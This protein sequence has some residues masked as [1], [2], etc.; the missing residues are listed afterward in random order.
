MAMTYVFYPIDITF[1]LDN[2]AC[3]V[4]LFGRTSDKKSITVIDTGYLPSF[5]IQTN[6]EQLIEEISRIRLK[7]DDKG[8]FVIAVK[9]IK[10]IINNLD[11]VFYQVFVNRPKAISVI[12][13]AATRKGLLVLENDVPFLNKYLLDN[14]VSFFRPYLVEGI[15]IQKKIRTDIIVE[16]SV[17]EPAIAPPFHPKILAV[18][19]LRLFRHERKNN[20]IAMIN[21]FSKK[22]SGTLTYLDLEAN[23][24]ERS[25]SE[26]NLIEMFRDMVIQEQPDIIAGYGSDE[27]LYTLKKRAVIY[28]VDLKLGADFSEIKYTKVKK[29]ARITG[30]LHI[31]LKK[32]ISPWTTTQLESDDFDLD[33]IRQELGMRNN[34]VDLQ[35]YVH[36]APKMKIRI[37]A[38][39]EES[40]LVYK[41]TKKLF[42]VLKFLID[43]TNSDPFNLTRNSYFEIIEAM[44]LKQISESNNIIPGLPDKSMIEERATFKKSLPGFSCAPGYYKELCG[45]D[46]S[47][48]KKKLITEYNIS[49]DTVECHCCKIEHSDKEIWSCS[50]K[51]GNIPLLIK[52]FDISPEFSGIKRYFISKIS[53]Y[54]NFTYSR[55]YSKKAYEK[56]IDRLEKKII[57]INRVLEE[58]SFRIMYADMSRILFS[59]GSRQECI[60]IC[61]IL[62]SDIIHSYY[63]SA[64]FF[65]QKKSDLSNHC[66]LLTE[67]GKMV[68][69]G[70]DH[71]RRNYA[72]IVRKTWKNVLKMILQGE[73]KHF[74]LIQIKDI[75]KK[76]RNHEI[77][78]NDVIIETQL[79]KEL[80]DY[81][82]TPPHVA[83]ARQ[84][85]KQGNIISKGTAIRYIIGKG[86][87]KISQRTMLP[88]D[89]EKDDYDPEYY[90]H[91]QLIR[92]L[93]PIIR[94]L[95]YTEDDV[96]Q[97]RVQSKLDGF[98]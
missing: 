90:I 20:P 8:Y 58:N 7:I 93:L 75:I 78:L 89:A 60:D 73:P 55:I 51:T 48:I 88:D 15:P 44:L 72:P 79:M 16:K 97:D 91:N 80:D 12:S 22:K 9:K 94:A 92:A 28:D 53:N 49:P 52:S 69:C 27:F 40:R 25:S 19:S 77:G 57:D 84:S 59:V 68:E 38:L 70:P 45:I 1:E 64:F 24:F 39:G 13:K 96:L 87:E 2:N 26:K 47:D 65:S 10:K 23:K 18:R 83:A 31:D 81:E 30:M 86:A 14:N 41:L 4:L 62:D 32:F 6:N 98:V 35:R 5:L 71:S 50:K 76:I 3:N 46:I 43:N 11:T 33:F 66:M 74:V 34:E 85:Q 29:R 54:L 67:S 56:I 82:V 42:P 36:H 63:K 37:K 61:R 17:M 95:G 21:I